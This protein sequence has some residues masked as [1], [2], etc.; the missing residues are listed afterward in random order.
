M[1]VNS[2]QL[3]VASLLL[4]LVVVVNGNLNLFMNTTETRRL[5]GRSSESDIVSLIFIHKQNPNLNTV[6]VMGSEINTLA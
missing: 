1:A 2:S 3:S 5:L 6:N 4:L